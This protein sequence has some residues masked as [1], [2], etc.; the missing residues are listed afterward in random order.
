MRSKNSLLL[1][2]QSK[3]GILTR[4]IIALLLWLGLIILCFINREY[5]SVE[6]IAAYT[7]SNIWLA[8]AAVLGLFAVKSFSFFIY[9]GILYAAC[10]VIF[11]LPVALLVNLCGTAIMVS[12]PYWLGQKA[13]EPMID[14]IK[15]NHPKVRELEQI[16]FGNEIFISAISRLVGIVPSDPVSMYMGAVRIH[17]FKYLLG[18]LVGFLPDIV[19]F[20]VMGLSVSEIR[21][22]QFII[23]AGGKITLTVISIIV[24]LIHRKKSKT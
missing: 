15:A 9:V 16:R 20:S 1:W 21:S 18:S 11:P 6:S 22:P 24:M 7:P 14:R 2:A 13:G 23:A 19:A 4:R 8:A 12:L 10:G 3:A 5:I 17:F